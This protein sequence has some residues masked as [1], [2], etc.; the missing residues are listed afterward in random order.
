MDLHIC[1]KQS[2]LRSMGD[3][4]K[5]WAD[6]RLAPVGFGGSVLGNLYQAISETS[7]VEAVHRAWQSGVRYF[8]TAP[9]YGMG[10]SE[11]RLGLAL[12]DLPRRDVVLSTKVGR[13]LDPASEDLPPLRD[14][15][16]D[17]LPNTVRF[18]YSYDG[19]MR[20]FE[21][22]LRR[23]G[24]DKVEVLFAHDLGALTHGSMDAHHFA[25]FADGGYRAMDEL[26]GSG[27]VEAIGLGVNET[28][29]IDQ[30]MAIGRFDCFLLA[31]RYTL[32]EQGPLSGFFDR[33]A[34]HG[35]RIVAGGVYNSGILATGTR[36]GQPVYC[37]YAPATPEV[38]ARVAR[39]EVLCDQA[40]VTLAAAALQFTCAH[41]IV[42]AALVGLG[43]A[44]LVDRT[45][46][47]AGMPIPASFW[48][49][50]KAE[51][52]IAASAPVSAEVQG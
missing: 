19:V 2:Y 46:A 29:V 8:D 50:M 37:D 33:V 47:L 45:L 40:G 15:F 52:I 42:A 11:Q 25:Q 38:I 44:D 22:S 3:G 9:Y 16:A 27:A 10:L 49:A 48:A 5:L 17:P 13:L 7:A 14:G 21:D 36:S 31:G 26:R 32:L 51:G 6:V 24:V 35:A 28:E 1:K 41:P 43:S 4:E 12:R 34:A 18:D 20:S 39:I 23:L 30:A